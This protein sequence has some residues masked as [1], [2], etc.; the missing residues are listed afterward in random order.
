MKYPRQQLA[1]SS[2]KQVLYYSTMED[3]VYK[4]ALPRRDFVNFTLK[5]RFAIE[6]VTQIQKPA[7]HLM[8]CH[9]CAK[10]KALTEPGSYKTL[11]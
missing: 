5:A 4:T 3:F 6:I 7:Q 9:W 8:P 1:T 2:A 11:V 10:A